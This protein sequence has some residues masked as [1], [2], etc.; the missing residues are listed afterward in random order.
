MKRWLYALLAAG[1]VMLSTGCATTSKDEDVSTMPWNRPQSWEGQGALG[2]MQPP[3][4][5]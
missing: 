3:G 4:S 5:H 1:S 2:G